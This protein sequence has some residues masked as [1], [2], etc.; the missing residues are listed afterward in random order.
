M[1]QNDDIIQRSKGGLY[2]WR[3]SAAFEMQKTSDIG[4]EASL[5]SGNKHNDIAFKT[6]AADETQGF[7]EDNKYFGI[8]GRIGMTYHFLPVLNFGL[9]VDLPLFYRLLIILCVNMTKTAPVPLIIPSVPLP[10][11][12][13]DWRLR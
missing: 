1:Y 3:L 6:A 4:A 11:C 7:I 8:G 2:N 10:Y 9:S 5:L 13:Q 12:V